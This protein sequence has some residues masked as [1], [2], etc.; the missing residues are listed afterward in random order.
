MPPDRFTDDF[1]QPFRAV[2]DP[3]ADAAVDGVLDELGVES[4]LKIRLVH[5]SVRRFI[6]PA[7]WDAAGLG[8][9]VNQEDMAMTLMA[10]DPL[11]PRS[12]TGADA[13][14][15]RG[16]RLRV[17]FARSGCSPLSCGPGSASPNAWK[18]GTRAWTA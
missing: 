1:L 9:P 3:P 18:T 17:P 5:A 2:A 4:A 14:R 15:P 10:H 6:P 13:G 8:E 11:L 12:G 16:F 7:D